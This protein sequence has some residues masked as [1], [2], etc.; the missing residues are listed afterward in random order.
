MNRIVLIS[1]LLLSSLLSTQ[2][3]AQQYPVQANISVAGPAPST[4]S[5]FVPGTSSRVN[6][7]LI[8]NDVSIPTLDVKLRFIF[9]G[10]GFTI[11]TKQSAI[12]PTYTLQGGVPVNLGIELEPY[13]QPTAFQLMNG[14]WGNFMPDGRLPE[15]NYLIK[16]QV[17]EPRRNVVISNTAIN[18]A[19]V[20]L[21]DPPMIVQPQ[22]GDQVDPGAVQNVMF[23]WMPRNSVFPMGGQQIQYKFEL[24]DVPP[25]SNPNVTAGSLP[26]TH[27]FNTQM[28]TLIWGPTYPILTPGQHYVARVTAYDPSNQVAF[29]NQ[30]KSEPIMY[31]YGSPCQT[32][33][34]PSHSNVGITQAQ[35][36]WIGMAGSESFRVE[37]IPSDADVDD[38]WRII[39]TIGETAKLRNL[40]PGK[41]YQYRIK[42]LCGGI[43]S[44]PTM[45]RSFTTQPME[46]LNNDCDLELETPEIDDEILRDNVEPLEMI[47]AGTFPLQI[48]EITNQN[49]TFYDGRGRINLPLFNVAIRANFENMQVTLYNKMASGTLTAVRGD[50]INIM[51]G[52]GGPGGSG[53]GPGGGVPPD[54]ADSTIMFDNGIEEIEMLDTGIW[55]VHLDDGTI[56]TVTV[57]ADGSI[58]ITDGE[59]TNVIVTPTDRFNVTPE[60][61]GGGQEYPPVIQMNYCE[62]NIKFEHHSMSKY[63]LERPRSQYPASYI[64][65]PFGSQVK[66]L[67]WKSMSTQEMGKLV[68]K[69]TL[70]DTELLRFQYQAGGDGVSFSG[71]PTGGYIVNFE[72][73][74]GGE[75]KLLAVCDRDDGEGTPPSVADAIGVVA[76]EPLSITL[77]VVPVENNNLN[78]TK[79]E[80]E[81][82]LNEI[83]EP[84]VVNWNVEF[85]EPLTYDLWDSNDDNLIERPTIDYSD[86]MRGVY[87]SFL[88][89]PDYGTFRNGEVLL[90]VIPGITSGGDINGYM[91]I[92]SRY[93]FVTS[94]ASKRDVAH[95]LGH[96]V[97]NLR[98]TFSAENV[99]Q[100]PQG[101]TNNLMDYSQG[102]ELWKYQW[103]FIHNPEG[104][105]HIFED[106]EE[107]EMITTN[108]FPPHFFNDDGTITFFSPS[109]NPIV[110]PTG[111]EGIKLFHGLPSYKYKNVVTGVLY[112]FKTELGTYKLNIS[113]DGSIFTYATESGLTYS[114]I[115][116]ND[117]N[118]EYAIWGLP[119]N[120]NTFVS[121]KVKTVSLESGSS[122]N[123]ISEINFPIQYYSSDNFVSSSESQLGKSMEFLFYS[124]Q[125]YVTEEEAEMIAGRKEFASLI[126]VLKIAQLR[127]MYPSHFENFANPDYWDDY[128]DVSSFDTIDVI[129]NGNNLGPILKVWGTYVVREGL[130][131]LFVSN[132]NNFYKIFLTSFI[133]YLE[134]NRDENS[135]FW[136]SIS[137]DNTSEE[138]VQNT[139]YLSENEIKAIPNS[140][141]KIGISIIIRD[142]KNRISSDLIEEEEDAIVKLIRFTSENNIDNMLAMLLESSL[143]DNNYKIAYA[144]IKGI[145]DTELFFIG[146]GNYN[147]L[148]TNL[149]WLWHQSLYSLTPSQT[150]IQFNDASLSEQLWNELKYRVTN[151]PNFAFETNASLNENCEVEYQQNAVSLFRTIGLAESVLKPFQPIYLTNGAEF[152]I[153]EEHCDLTGL[154]IFPAIL[155]PYADS[156]GNNQFFED[157]IESSIDV[158]SIAT[159]AGSLANGGKIIAR[160][161]SVSDILTSSANLSN[162]LG[163]ID[164]PDELQN[165]LNWSNIGT[166]GADIVTNLPRVV[167]NLEIFKDVRLA[168]KPQ[169]SSSIDYLS[170]IDIELTKGYLKHRKGKKIILYLDKVKKEAIERGHSNVLGKINELEEGWATNIEDLAYAI[171]NDK[172]LYLELVENL[173]SVN[174]VQINYSNHIFDLISAENRVI[175][176][177]T[178]EK[179]SLRFAE[180]DNGPYL[181]RGDSR[182]LNK[183]HLDGGLKPHGTK[184]TLEEHVL[185]YKLTR[186]ADGTPGSTWVSTTK[187]NPF[188]ANDNDNQWALWFAVNKTD[189]VDK[190]FNEGFVYI[191]K[192][193]SNKGFDVNAAENL[194]NS[195]KYA[196]Q[197]EVAFNSKIDLSDIEGA[198]LVR[199]EIGQDKFEIIDEFIPVSEFVN[200]NLHT[201]KT[202]RPSIFKGFGVDIFTEYPQVGVWINNITDET[203]KWQT[204]QKVSSWQDNLIVKLNNSAGW[205]SSAFINFVNDLEDATLAAKF[206]ENPGL[207]EAWK[208]IDDIGDNAFD[209]LRKD[210]DFLQKFDDVVNNDKLYSHTFNGD[211]TSTVGADGVTRH[212]VTGIHSNKAF[213]D[214]TARIKPGTEVTDLGDG[215]YKAKVEKQ[216]DGFVNDQGTNWKVKTDKS[217]FFP[218][219]WSTEKIQAEIANAFKNKISD[220][221]NK[222]H[223]FTTGDKKITM[224]LDEVGNIKTAFP[225]I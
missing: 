37:F 7:T 44:E 171:K 53:G 43:E 153:Y 124:R 198:V 49:G 225:D 73:P 26:S 118:S 46:E 123:V 167:N 89:V 179:A 205:E 152:S 139:K 38:E 5:G 85:L 214:G 13:F 79:A 12:V 100:A 172:N 192:D 133:N 21:N 51:N 83:Y 103:D 1:I 58:Y 184:G 186:N 20:M 39:D 137:E 23:S 160:V 212:K 121:Y 211:V 101:S 151:V 16:L 92:K 106:V 66:Q 147:K 149:I 61:G 129:A 180:L 59:D 80:L 177:K 93:G 74:E 63:G 208:K 154:H 219:A 104:G 102:T 75:G 4:I 99:F 162:N 6:A 132:P 150:N 207:V 86:E 144:L 29:K 10:P 188:R 90:F 47:L 22:D 187:E 122:G 77:K 113:E 130:Q 82:A 199:Q 68:V 218:D 14:A 24:W 112:A 222:F 196:S 8:M 224:F 84:A 209:Q 148:M 96:G 69:D 94:S 70:G 109:G 202:A 78:F 17:I 161:V 91:P 127:N 136:N 128:E 166:L 215:F 191:L 105:W 117:E 35:I 190:T 67:G 42:A 36:D 193:N 115:E 173:G 146:D 28:T 169:I 2:T 19:W 200:F 189:P 156:K 114:E 164:V 206:F 220:G 203:L 197:K 95:E 194:G 31:Q 107:G 34:N 195:H 45:E 30:G 182:N 217:T 41:S 155:L 50:D 40:G 52:G 168:T 108:Y 145:D 174:T 64:E 56:D 126:P 159:G 201:H 9:E 48:D 81:A 178:Y 11:Q 65:L 204:Y 76:Y 138:V 181:F 176:P 216:I 175:G 32:P 131:S 15:G 27:E 170:P 25:G 3:H 134:E 87:Q 213:V 60:N 119:V 57:P 54:E 62:R 163:A 125:Q 120:G 143:Y 116:N 88:A 55:I 97:F 221:G 142:A 111:V 71:D 141:K 157:I 210:P 135:N 185:R 110:L 140:K 18:M 98:H 183:I 72:A 158:V 33:I 165:L 223:G